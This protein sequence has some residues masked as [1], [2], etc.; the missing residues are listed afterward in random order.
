M[1]S[2]DPPSDAPPVVIAGRY[3]VL[4][5]LGQGG[6]GAVYRCEHTV[7]GRKCAVKRLL[8]QY[9]RD[10]EV[11]ERFIRESRIAGALDHPGIVEVLDAGMDEEG[12]FLVMEL[13]EG[14]S[15]EDAIDGGSLTDGALCAHV[16]DALRALGV[17]HGAGIV[18]RDIK[19]ANI[20][21]ARRGATVTV[22]ILD[23]GISKL[24]RSLDGAPGPNKK[25][26]RVGTVLGT[27]YFMAPEQ[28]RGAENLDATSDLYSMGVVL[29]Q[30]LT[31]ELPFDAANYNALLSAI[32]TDETPLVSKFRT[33]LPAGLVDV[34]RRA[35]DRA[36]EQRF[37]TAAAMADALEPFCALTSRR[38]AHELALASTLPAAG[39][40]VAQPIA[41]T[42][43]AQ[44]LAPI[45]KPP[46]VRTPTERIEPPAE[47]KLEPK[48][49]VTALTIVAAVL[50][51]VGATLVIV[52]ATATTSGP[53][54][55][56]PTLTV[57]AD[58][59]EPAITDARDEDA[60]SPLDAQSRPRP[61]AREAPRS[62]ASGASDASDV[63]SAMDVQRVDSGVAVEPDVPSPT[64][65]DRAI[66]ASRPEGGRRGWLIDGGFPMRLLDAGR[67]PRVGLDGGG[68]RGRLLE[69]LVG[70]PRPNKSTDL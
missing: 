22:K 13:L 36:P 23:F 18:H 5:T 41:P 56:T 8:P 1:T 9:A 17:A 31:G 38:A 15:L 11:V 20:F 32:L 6:M 2:A 45:P 61:R 67:R 66:D 69:N 55:P 48:R 51:G 46:V 42:D 28:A 52:R 33:D 50:V 30:G 3:R 64:R 10:G 59:T 58:A 63:R 34:I 53:E 37:A 54:P 25:L 68:R 70:P 35:M 65:P 19:P 14:E 43:R 16:R 49:A 60:R 47:P 21:I 40:P 24:E 62:T 57:L 26:T 4:S 12:A 29:F 39:S 27:P 44:A 7:T